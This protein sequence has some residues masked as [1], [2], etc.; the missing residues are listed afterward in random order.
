MTEKK[1]TVQVH[2]PDHKRDIDIVVS[3]FSFSYDGEC[4][5]VTAERDGLRVNL[6][7]E[8]DFQPLC[9][10]VKPNANNSVTLCS[11]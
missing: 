1:I 11:L 7:A 8:K 9:L 10:C 3:A 4:F 6:H 5:V 2:S